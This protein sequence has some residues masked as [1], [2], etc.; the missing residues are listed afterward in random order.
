MARNGA[1]RAACG[2]RTEV[3]K[4]NIKRPLV[5]SRDTNALSTAMGR[6]SNDCT[7]LKRNSQT[8]AACAVPNQGMDGATARTTHLVSERHPVIALAR[9]SST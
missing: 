6:P 5:G 8:C 4:S 2:G 1:V 9:V 7:G 3:E